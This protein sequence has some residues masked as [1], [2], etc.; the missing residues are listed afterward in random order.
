[1]WGLELPVMANTESSEK[2]IACA[3]LVWLWTCENGCNE[4]RRIQSTTGIDIGRDQSNLRLEL[5][6]DRSTRIAGRLTVHELVIIYHWLGGS[7]FDWMHWN[8]IGFVLSGEVQLARHSVAIDDHLKWFSTLLNGYCWLKDWLGAF[9]CT[10]CW[11]LTLYCKTQQ[12]P[13]YKDISAVY[14]GEVMTHS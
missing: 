3:R 10:H 12:L 9:V 7:R 13:V 2:N 4:H 8:R 6:F 1:M 5:S 14:V 11:M